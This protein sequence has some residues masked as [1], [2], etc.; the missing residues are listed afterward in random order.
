MNNYL[1]SHFSVL[2]GFG[3]LIVRFFIFFKRKAF[4]E[5]I[6]PPR[7]HKCNRVRTYEQRLSILMDNHISQKALKPPFRVNL[8]PLSLAIP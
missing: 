7:Q 5:Q 6:P 3:P 4:R 2:C 8:R 1:Q